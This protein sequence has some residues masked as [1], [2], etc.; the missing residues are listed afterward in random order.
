MDSGSSQSSPGRLT[1]TEEVKGS[2]L[3]RGCCPL[4]ELGQ[5]KQL[6]FLGRPRL[7]T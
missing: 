5:W 7:S 4:T 2:G 6:V 3:V 1:L